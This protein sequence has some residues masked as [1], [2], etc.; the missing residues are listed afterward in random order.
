MTTRRRSILDRATFGPPP[1][2]ALN[3]ASDD[4]PQAPPK[5]AVAPIVRDTE[6]KLTF[7]PG[8]RSFAALW[9]R[10]SVSRRKRLA[11]LLALIAVPAL[12][13]PGD[14]GAMAGDAP[15]EAGGLPGAFEDE[16]AMPFERPGLSFPG[17]AFYYLADPPHDA[18]VALP[19]SNP[20]T[21]GAPGGREVGA[22]I[23]AGPAARPFAAGV[24]P[25][26]ARAQDCLAQAIWYEAASESVAGQRAV[27]QVV[28]NR[29]AHASWPASVCGVVYQGSE[30]KTGCQF[31]FTCDGSLARQARG[32]AW[33][34][35]KRI[36][37]DA[38]DGAVYAPIGH[39]THYHTLWVSPRWA[40]RLDPVGTIGAH[41]FYRNRGSAGEASA[42][43]AA[44]SGFEPSVTPGPRAERSAYKGEPPARNAEPA[45]LEPDPQALNAPARAAAPDETVSA[46]DTAPDTAPYTGPDT[47]LAHPELRAVGQAREAFA[48]AG[49]WKVDPANLDLSG[50]ES[51]ASQDGSRTSP[52]R[53]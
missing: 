39:A 29:V 4:A 50:G 18:L 23:D 6:A 33:E 14:F 34:A 30:R 49:Q 26:A 51:P 47:A 20:A 5:A 31:S 22:L 16:R 10:S 44:Y 11:A 17:S 53:F 48:K 13:A 1:A 40:T 9:P 21:R 12:A 46:P 7:R 27:A 52:D 41:R 2:V 35:A 15:G 8:I 38:L 37:K 28:L 32:R 25:H 45:G 24:G 3:R 43:G 19:E 42:F 36:A